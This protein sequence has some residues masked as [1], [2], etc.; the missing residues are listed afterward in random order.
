MPT[1]TGSL[2]SRASTSGHPSRY[3]TLYGLRVRHFLGIG[4]QKAGTTWLHA[5]LQRHPQVLVPVP[6]KEWHYFD[7]VCPTRTGLSHRDLYL[8]QIR[9]HLQAELDGPQEPAVTR[10]VLRRLDKLELTLQ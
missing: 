6:H 7:S 5:Q 9:Q 3:L 8:R 10:Q 4:A 1:G 2:A